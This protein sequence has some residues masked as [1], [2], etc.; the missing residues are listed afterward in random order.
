M[1][2]PLIRPYKSDDFEV[3]TSFW[4]RAN[5]QFFLASKLHWPHTFEEDQAYFRSVILIK[6]DVWV[7][8]V[9][10]KPVAYMAISDDFIAQLH[11]DLDFH[12]QGIGTA[13][14]DHAKIL[15]PKFLRLYTL[16][17]NTKAGKFYGVGRD[18]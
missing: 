17:A 8:E 12:R 3:V 5:E 9:N 1:R 15:S 4:R 2:N 14:L 18:L 10:G 7:A 13:L 16:Q 11:V 6:D